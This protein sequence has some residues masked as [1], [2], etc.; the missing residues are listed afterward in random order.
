MHGR[1]RSRHKPDGR[2]SHNKGRPQAFVGIF[3][4]RCLTIH[5]MLMVLTVAYKLPHRHSVWATKLSAVH[6][7]PS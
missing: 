5:S 2:V 3:K 1:G 4:P 7:I 6:A